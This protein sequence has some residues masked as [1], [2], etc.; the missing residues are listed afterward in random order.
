MTE[1]SFSSHQTLDD[2][3]ITAIERPLVEAINTDAPPYD[4]IPF[5]ISI[6]DGD[7]V[8]G[9]LTGYSVWNWLYVDSLGIDPAYR[10]NDYALKLMQM[11]EEE[12]LKRDCV[13]VWVHTISFQAPGFY[14]KAGYEEFGHM[15]NCPIGHQRIFF[16]KY[17]NNKEAKHAG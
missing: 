8:I 11:A 6:K 17:L 9:G 5:E 15:D 14:K 2:E 3:L 10:G 12:A 16:R 1:I 13:G 4:K 7:K